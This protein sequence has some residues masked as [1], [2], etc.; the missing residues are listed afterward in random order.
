[1]K[2]KPSTRAYRP[3]RIRFRAID[4]RTFLQWVGSA[5]ALSTTGCLSEEGGEKREEWTDATVLDAL[6]EISPITPNDEHY[7]VAYLGMAD[8]DPED[9]SFQVFAGGVKRGQFDLEALQAL[10]KRDKEHTLQCIESSPEVQRMSN[11]VWSG[12]PLPEIFEALNIALPEGPE[13]AHLR[14]ECA[15]GRVDGGRRDAEY[16]DVTLYVYADEGGTWSEGGAMW[17]CSSV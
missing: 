9:W 11:A 12:L 1:M 7:V 6:P 17:G 15:D 8:V 14:F 5:A 10:P 2:E 13:A 3:G 4:R 16:P